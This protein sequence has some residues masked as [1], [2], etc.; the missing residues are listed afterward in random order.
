MVGDE[1]LVVVALAHN[2]EF[3]GPGES[4][5]IDVVDYRLGAQESIEGRGLVGFGHRGPGVEHEAVQLFQG[6]PVFQDF[7]VVEHGHAFAFIGTVR[8]PHAECGE[9]GALFNDILFLVQ[10]GLLHSEDVRFNGVQ[11]CRSGDIT[12]MTE[13]KTIPA[14]S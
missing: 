10:K 8:A 11:H 1:G 3:I 4:V 6:L 5:V 13:A 12:P 9:T 7:G 14:R 2:P